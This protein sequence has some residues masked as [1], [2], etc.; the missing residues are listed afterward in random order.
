MKRTLLAALLA[1]GALVSAQS[2]ATGIDENDLSWLYVAPTAKQFPADSGK[3]ASPSPI[4]HFTDENDFSS[5]YVAPTAKQFP[6]DSGAPAKV[7][8][9]IVHIGDENDLSW[10]YVAPTAKSFRDSKYASTPTAPVR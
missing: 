1:T 10:L 8:T 2:F 7:L 9:A 4:A 3:P 6:A 5:L